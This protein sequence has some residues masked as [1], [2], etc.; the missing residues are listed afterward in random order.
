MGIRTQVEGVC[1]LPENGGFFIME[2]G[3]EETVDVGADNF[4]DVQI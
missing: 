1:F 4:E 2:G 3:K